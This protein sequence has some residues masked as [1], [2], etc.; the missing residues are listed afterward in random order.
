MKTFLK[1]FFVGVCLVSV[2]MSLPALAQSNVPTD[3][4]AVLTGQVDSPA[5][6]AVTKDNVKHLIETLE[7]D[8]AR[9]ELITNL[10]IL[11]NAQQKTDAKKPETILPEIPVLTEEIGLRGKIRKT[12]KEYNKFLDQKDVSSSAVRQSV[13]SAIAVIFAAIFFF[14]VRS[15]A[16]KLMTK[17]DHLSEKIGVKLSRVAFYTNVLQF[18]FRVFIVGA[19]IYTLGK[20]WELAWVEKIFES[21]EM[22]SALSTFVTVLFVATIAAFIWES[23]GIYLAYI[24]KQADDNNQTRVKTLLPIIRNI[25]LSIFGI[26]FGLM[27]LSEFGINVGPLIAGAGVVGVAIGFGAQSMV[28]DFLTG[29]TIVLEDVVRVGD[30]VALGGATGTV[31]KI[32]LR[33]IQLRDFGG[34]VSTIPFSQITTIQN[35]TKKFSFHVVRIG[36]SYDQD[37]DAAVRV[38]CSVDAELRD[39]PHF[40]TMILEPIEILGVDEFADSAVMIKARMKTEAGKQWIVGREYNRRLKIA[41]DKNGIEIPF[42]QRV[43]TVRGDTSPTLTPRDLASTVD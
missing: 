10:Q 12:V 19:L 43:I 2:S 32:T 1:I 21:P 4:L 34:I 22:K 29:F 40:T 37:T 25:I 20:I 8:T 9:K 33:K 23:V 26:L 39:D 35:L 36:V 7:S 13:G 27:L 3:P 30:V 14:T 5:D 18:I 24:L 31:E 42:P 11:I 38:M 16:F 41:F 17:L 15:L 6:S 28:K